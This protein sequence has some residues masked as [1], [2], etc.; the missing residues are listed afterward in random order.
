MSGRKHFDTLRAAMTPA[1]RIAVAEKVAVLRAE[2]TLAELRQARQLTQETLSGTLHVGQAAVA[3]M[4]KRT[5][6]YVGNLRRFVEAMGG[7]LDVVARFPEGSVKISNFAE[8]GED[9]SVK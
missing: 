1:Q 2:M 7:Q 3:K 9:D 5:D 6:M 8:I 4:E